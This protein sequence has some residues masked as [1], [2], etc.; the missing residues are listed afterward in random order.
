MKQE[1]GTP[2]KRSLG[3]RLNRLLSILLAACLVLQPPLA[4]AEGGTREADPQAPED[5][6]TVNAADGI[7]QGDP[8]DAD[9]QD[10][11]VPDEGGE[12]PD[13]VGDEASD[14][15]QPTE[16]E[17]VEAD[18]D[19]GAPQFGG[20]RATE[21]KADGGDVDATPQDVAEPAG[22]PDAAAAD[23]EAALSVQA[24]EAKEPEKVAAPAA[25]AASEKSK[26]AQAAKKRK[27]ISSAK[28]SNVIF[29]G[30]A[31][32]TKVVVKYG[33]KKLKEGRDYKVT[34]KNNRK[35]GKATAVVKG[36]GKYK[37][38]KKARFRIYGKPTYKRGATKMPKGSTSSWTLK[39]ATMKV[40]KGSSVKVSGKTVTARKA[41]VSTIGIYNRLGKRVAAKTVTV[42]TFEGPV[43]LKTGTA[44]K[45]YLQV[46]DG[47]ATLQGKSKAGEQFFTLKASG[48]YYTILAQGSGLAL[49]PKKVDGEFTATLAEAAA[50]GS[51]AQQWE[52]SADSKN[53]LA[54]KNRKTGKVL[55]FPAGKDAAGQKVSLRKA[56]KKPK[57]NLGWKVKAVPATCK[58]GATFMPVGSTSKWTIANCKVRITSGKDVV[59][60]KDGTFTA[61]KKGTAT[62]SVVDSLG[63]ELLNRT[64]SVYALGSE[65]FLDSVLSPGRVVD[66]DAWKTSNG[67]NIII[68]DSTG[69]VNQK[70]VFK[71]QADGSYK[72]KS[73]YSGNM[74]QASHGQGVAPDNVEQWKA[75]S[76]PYQQW[77]ITVDAKNRLSFVNVGSGKAMAL[78]GAG[79]AAG[80]NIMLAKP[81]NKDAQK[82]VAIDLNAKVKGKAYN[83][84]AVYACRY[85]YSQP[86]WYKN[87]SKNM[88]TKL[89]KQVCKEVFPGY[90][91]MSCDKGVAAAA[92]WSGY[93]F[94]YPAEVVAQYKYLKN[95]PDW[96][97]LGHWSGKESDLQ[98]GDVLIR[99]TNMTDKY[100]G[101]NTHHTCVYVGS[102]VAM[103]VYNTY[104]KGT[105]GDLGTPTADATF[106]SAHRGWKNPNRQAAA[107]IGSR[108]YAYADSKMVVFRCTNPNDSIKYAHI[109]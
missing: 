81:A 25:P 4:F 66:I 106:V 53:R 107:C 88:G 16:D 41:G 103:A 64:I 97:Y 3:T 54:F 31:T 42:Y 74:L 26:P 78:E 35:P 22:S 90:V 86:L 46:A 85:A 45:L 93:D 94:D 13:G 91:A 15:A 7:V 20:T 56:P 89:F 104:I 96:K 14:P 19:D 87:N 65:Y 29:T 6:L 62:V 49:Q 80:T 108:S 32:K 102:E 67:G 9:A 100:P 75:A 68:W 77:N 36:I 2:A 109:G 34:Y 10:A 71:K 48:G 51:K 76:T 84:L 30:K 1:T 17:D 101:T 8:G 92:R 5:A 44:A 69:L 28:A 50:T 98:P 24:V 37:G 70:F 18:G 21:Q 27:K 58:G 61:L 105:D 52:V 33:K 83:K 55:G 72:I 39:N 59:S 60:Y 43:Y 38:T 12:A 57:D 73:S 99:T 82:F 23:D 47:E 11:D 79:T 40:V 63:T 95:S